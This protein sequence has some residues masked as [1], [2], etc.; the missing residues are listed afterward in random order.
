MRT[1]KYERIE[2]HQDEP[3]Q[4]TAQLAEFVLDLPYLILSRRNPTEACP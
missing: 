3:E 1:V 4:R 2:F